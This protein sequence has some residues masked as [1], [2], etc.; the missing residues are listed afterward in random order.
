[1]RV[2]LFIPCYIE[3][4]YPQVGMAALS[5]LERFGVAV[6]YPQGQTCC[7]QPMA[8]TGCHQE[9][10]PVARKFIELF[11][12]YDYVV[13]PTASYVAMIRLHYTSLF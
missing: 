6:E 8:N 9:T 12:P 1:M 7:G 2:G 11:Q 3:Q 13:G 5:V 10:L 4:F